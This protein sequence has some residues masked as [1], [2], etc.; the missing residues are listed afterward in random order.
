MFDRKVAVGAPGPLEL[1]RTLSWLELFS[2]NEEHTAQI[3]RVLGKALDVVSGGLNNDIRA[4]PLDR[5]VGCVQSR[6][7]EQDSKR[8]RKPHEQKSRVRT[9]AHPEQM[10]HKR[11]LLQYCPEHS[12]TRCRVE[13]VITVHL[14]D[15]AAISKEFLSCQC[16]SVHAKLRTQPQLRTVLT[17]APAAGASA[18]P[19]HRE[20]R[21][22]STC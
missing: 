4:P 9:V 1:T 19:K 11:T 17:T 10:R 3:S 6:Q 21:P 22:L 20:D 14:G 5:H 15:T 2:G 13:G 18:G 12:L 8:P 7:Y 16:H